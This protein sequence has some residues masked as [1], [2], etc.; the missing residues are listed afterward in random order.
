MAAEII[1]EAT[2]GLPPSAFGLFT[3]PSSIWDGL[4]SLGAGSPWAVPQDSTHFSDLDHHFQPFWHEDP[5]SFD[6]A[7]IQYE[8]FIPS[9]RSSRHAPKEGHLFQLESPAAE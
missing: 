5:G 3:D 7:I 4:E 9:R 6:P 8:R 1:L 2:G